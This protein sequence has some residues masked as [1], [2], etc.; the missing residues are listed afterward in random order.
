MG[1]KNKTVMEVE[2]VSMMAAGIL[3]SEHIPLFIVGGKEIGGGFRD[4]TMVG[5]PGMESDHIL[6]VLKRLVRILDGTAKKES[7]GN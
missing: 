7:E 1:K 5:R 3:N 2:N 4:Y 6:Y